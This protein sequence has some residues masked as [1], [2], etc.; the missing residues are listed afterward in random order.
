LNA[1]C[2]MARPAIRRRQ[3]AIASANALGLAGD[4]RSVDIE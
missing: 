1:A 2:A 4:Q 3:G